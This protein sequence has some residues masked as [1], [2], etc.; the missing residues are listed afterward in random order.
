MVN[1]RT[2]RSIKNSIYAV[3]GQIVTIILNFVSRTIFISSLG[4]VYLGIN[5]LFTN[6]LSV[7]SFAELGFSTAIIYEMYKP[8]ADRNIKIVSG[9]VNF[10]QKVYQSIGLGIF[11]IGLLLIPYLDFFIKD[12][13][14]LPSDIPP[15]WFIYLLFLV[16]TSLSY[17][18]NYKRSIV[19]A[20]Q[21]G[22]I[23]SINQLQFNIL[24]NVLQ[25]IVLLSFDSFIGFLIIQLLCTF[26]GNIAIS[27]KADKLFPY[28]KENKRE[29]ISNSLLKSIKKNVIAQS[30]NKL[31]S[32]VVSGIDNLFIAK[33]VGVIAVGCYSNYLLI[34]T[35]LRTLFTQIF[36]PVTASVGDFMTTSNKEDSF[37][38]F[39]K[40]LFINVYLSIVFSVCLAVLIN[41]FIS[42]FWG[43]EYVFDMYLVLAIVL[44]FYIDRIRLTSQMFIDAKGLF[45]QI[46][47][48]SICEAFINII[49]CLIFTVWLDL[50]LEGIILALL[51]CN[52]FI[53]FWW[54]A[55]VVFKYL[56]EKSIWIFLKLHFMYMAILVVIYIFLNALTRQLPDD[57]ISFFLKTIITFI[58]SNI[59]LILF[60]YKTNEFKYMR[61]II[62]KIIKV[63]Q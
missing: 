16:N 25:I 59:L 35:T 20:S 31:G 39:K 40:L 46:K 54:E 2:N 47:W 5:G 38:F 21:N 44:N 11:L 28:L 36:I 4:A 53:N 15:L 45:W 7:L 60:F 22:Y 10:Y 55:Y 19:V 58:I 12:V 63:K 37:L 57:Y 61:N 30:F 48:R 27:K 51:L 6:I 32:V 13:S 1:N 62:F 34:I 56:F 52:L 50:K 41:S 17:F 23:D 26:L 49:L 14:V 9:L 42:I 29:K 3:S 33:F 8:L 18:F 43:K 24:K